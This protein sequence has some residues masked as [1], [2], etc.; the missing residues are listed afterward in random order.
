LYVLVLAT[1]AAPERRRLRK[2]RRRLAGPSPEPTPVDTSRATVIDV[3]EPLK[4]EAEA[5]AWLA[6][7]GEPELSAGVAVINRALYVSRLVAAD[8]YLN[9]VS[10]HQALVAR[11]GYGIGEQVADGRW[12]EAVEL[13]FPAQRR[14][15]RRRAALESQAGLA[16]ALGGRA[17]TLICQELVL[18]A[19]LDVEQDRLR[20]AA[21]QTLA[22]L[23]AALTELPADP[24]AAGLADRIAELRKLR[25]PVA[26]AASTALSREPS[27]DQSGA[28]ELAL[29]RL[30]AALRARTYL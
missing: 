15:A 26:D 13:S 14:R 5:A 24:G 2:R 16:A 25:G 11:V 7:A 23:D 9:P 29:G 28:V 3:S 10:R 19:R 8:P 6:G 1:L 20:E 21:L 17:P 22:A 27:R 18:R 12:Q 30:E 4:S